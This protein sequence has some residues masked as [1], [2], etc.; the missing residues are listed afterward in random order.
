MLMSLASTPLPSPSFP[1]QRA[2][3][4]AP[5]SRFPSA[6][7]AGFDSIEFLRST[8]SCGILVSA[9]DFGLQPVRPKHKSAHTVTHRHAIESSPNLKSHEASLHAKCYPRSRP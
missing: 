8:S 3:S 2:Q 6:M 5:Y 1:W 7:E 4:V 9:A